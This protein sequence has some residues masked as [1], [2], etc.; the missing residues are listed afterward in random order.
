[1]KTLA[2]LIVCLLV[3]FPLRAQMR[4]VVIQKLPLGAE[5]E[6]ASPVFSHDGSRVYLT[7]AA[8]NGIWEYTLST[9]SLRQITD[10]PKSG[11]G[12]VVSDDDGMISYRSTTQESAGPR[13]QE[14]LTQGITS[15]VVTSI[16]KGESVSLPKFVRSSLVYL[17]GGR[18]ATL[19]STESTASPVLL[20]IENTKIVLSRNGDKI[21]L[22]PLKDGSYIW[23]S[24]SPDGTKLLAYEMGRGT[25]IS[26]L[27]G[28]ILEMLGR[29]DNP[30]WTRDGK[31]IVYTDDKD[32]GGA[33]MSSDICAV[34]AD[35]AATVR[36]TDTKEVVELYPS[37]SRMEDKIICSSL[38]GDVY[39][40]TYS[41]EKGQ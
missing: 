12:F 34:S 25:F 3:V 6:W 26:D 20:G 31:W 39:V 14:L 28:N 2:S 35:G 40:I 5:Q 37:C 41:E 24:L 16:E 29:K 19:S 18:I 7:N 33:I 22:D 9:G 10:A 15:G 27:D 1:M 23:A 4:A 11:F 38:S 30:V 32:D 13:S 36:L 17:K 21:I 8:F